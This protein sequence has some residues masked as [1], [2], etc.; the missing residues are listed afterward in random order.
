MGATRH[1][2]EAATAI[3]PTISEEFVTFGG[4]GQTDGKP[5]LPPHQRGGRDGSKGTHADGD[6]GYGKLLVGIVL[7]ALVATTYLKTTAR[8]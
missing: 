4:W 3:H 6:M 7:G 8:L 2:L 5:V 1:D